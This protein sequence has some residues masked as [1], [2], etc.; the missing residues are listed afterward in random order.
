MPRANRRRPERP[1]GPLNPAGM[2]RVETGADGDWIVRSLTGGT[3]TKSYRCPGCAQLIPPSTAH[4][5]AWPATGT[6]TRDGGADE[7]RHWKGSC[8]RARDTCRHR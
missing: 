8:W 6:F 2:Q 3:S 7:R 1:T 4:V 5:V